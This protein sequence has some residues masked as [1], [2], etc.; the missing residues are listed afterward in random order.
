MNPNKIFVNYMNY[1]VFFP[2][3]LSK[4]LKQVCT[5]HINVTERKILTAQRTEKIR[6]SDLVN[7]D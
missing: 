2:G 1:W 3:K 7:F 5:I 6:D 4:E